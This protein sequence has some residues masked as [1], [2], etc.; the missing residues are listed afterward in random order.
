M[1][2]SSAL[3]KRRSSK[4]YRGFESLPHRFAM[5][6][7]LYEIELKVKLKVSGPLGETTLER[8]LPEQSKAVVLIRH[9]FRFEPCR[10]R[11]GE[12]RANRDFATNSQQIFCLT[13]PLWKCNTA[14]GA[15]RIF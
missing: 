3:L 2:E 15:A 11:S 10:L 7:R 12:S 13:R 8:F 14:D 5:R 1:V 4:G 9:G 6:R